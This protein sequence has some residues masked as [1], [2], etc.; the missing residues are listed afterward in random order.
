MRNGFRFEMDNTDNPTIYNRVRKK[1]LELKGNIRC[2]FCRY[3]KGENSSKRQ[4]S[5]KKRRK[6][7]YRIADMV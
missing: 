6:T 4:K 1:Y 7:R 3:H 5:W 2:S